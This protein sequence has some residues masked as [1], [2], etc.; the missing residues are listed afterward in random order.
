MTMIATTQDLMV[1][2]VQDFEQLPVDGMFEVV[3]GRAILM[4]ANDSTHQDYSLGI[5]NLF[6]GEFRHLGYGYVCQALNVFIPRPPGSI[7]EVQNRIPDI[8]VSR[9]RP[10][11]HYEAGDPP[12]LVIEILSTRRGK[13][14][15]TEKM[16]D[17]ALAGIAEYWIVDPFRR[18]VEV[19]YLEN[20]DYTLQ[21]R[22]PDAALAP[23]GFPGVHITPAEI[24]T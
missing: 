17:Y 8:V 23:R 15:R 4:P 20:G 11:K 2:T 16:D 19:Y 13:V 12:E 24:W 10:E 6:L 3:D 18:L 14:E 22:E 5:A 1:Y 7:G 21:T 9:R